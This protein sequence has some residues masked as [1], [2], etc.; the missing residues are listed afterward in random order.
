MEKF[1]WIEPFEKIS[2]WLLEYKDKR[3]ELIPILMNIG[4]ENGLHDAASNKDVL[5]KDIDPFSF[6]AQIL[7]YGDSN[8]IKLLTELNT[9]VKINYTVPND[10]SGVPNVMS[11]KANLFSYKKERGESD[12]TILWNLFEAIHKDHNIEINFNKALLVKQTALAKLTQMMFVLFPN[13][14]FPID[15][16]TVTW[17]NSRGF[18]TNSYIQWQEYSS[19]LKLIKQNYKATLACLS[20]TCWYINEKTFNKR[21]A[22]ELLSI[23]LHR[24]TASVEYIK[25][26]STQDG[27]QIALE[28]S[29]KSEYFNII[30]EDKIPDTLGLNAQWRK[31]GNANLARHAPKLANKEVCL[32]RTNKNFNWYDFLMLLDWYEG[33][34]IMFTDSEN[35]NDS[36]VDIIKSQIHNFP[37][38]QILYGPPG[39]G[40]TYATTEL[41]VQ[42]ADPEWYTSITETHISERHKIIK[43]KYDELIKV[44]QI[45]FTTFH[46]SFSYEDFIEG[47]KAYIPEDEKNIAYKIEDG[48]FKRITIAAMK[49]QGIHQSDIGL[50]QEPTIWKI[51]LGERWETERRK[52]YFENGQARIG[53]SNVGD[54]R[55][56]RTEKEQLY[57]DSLKSNTHSTLYDFSTRI[58]IGDIVLCLK[59]QQTIRAIG[60]VKSDYYYDVT[61]EDDYAHVRDVNWIAKNISLNILALNDQKNLT[62]KTVY[63]LYRMSW[64][65]II[66]E[67]KKQN[68]EIDGLTTSEVAVEQNH[69]YVL[70]MDEINRGNI[71]KIFGELITL[72][73]D[74][75]RAGKPDAREL[76]LPYSK[77]PFTVPSNLYLIGTMNTADKSLTQLDL[78]LRRRF[79]FKEVGPDIS[80]LEKLGA[81]QYDVDIPLI[82]RTINQRIKYLKGKDYQIG[83]SYFMTLCKKMDEAD[84]LQTLKIVFQNKII[85]LLQEYFFSNLKHIGLVLNDNPADGDE[86]KI[87]QD[88]NIGENIFGY[89]QQ[90]K[91]NP[92][93]AVELNLDCFS[94]LKRFQQIYQ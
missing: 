26:F 54:L 45:A 6:V 34:N 80:I 51:S 4:V 19:L 28:I 29:N 69:N 59:D 89:G 70:V 27:K 24:I 76:T 71:S 11:V 49:S 17:L 93:F 91:V 10:F 50:N 65:N 25:G 94:D 64:S 3:N 68:I 90:P 53:W 22:E 82:L 21:N 74:D 73:E 61:G 5:L 47:L 75:K 43:E 23:R 8:R 48:I 35:K 63:E 62:L 12:I 14:F 92:L 66:E 72:I 15:G 84:Y 79:E 83:H 9:N 1:T 55:E 78:A 57:Y 18:P 16:Q 31:V 39:T 13:K 87:I 86:R 40:K 42:I 44:K 46:Q 20:H 58:K 41:A 32:I 60:V 52:R 7:K 67:L 81:S 36:E 2:K 56:Y 38:N 37:L 30:F 33:S 85:P 77:E 88:S